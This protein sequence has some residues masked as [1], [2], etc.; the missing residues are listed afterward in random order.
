MTPLGIR[1]VLVYAVLVLTLAMLGAHG[2]QRYLA[3][4]ELIDAKDEALITLAARRA[5]AAAVNGPLAITRWAR[6]HGMVPAPEAADVIQVAPSPLRPPERTFLP[7][8]LEVRTV[9]R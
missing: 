7:V 6:E 9:W 3:H 8:V 2:Q 1:A 4:A 5:E